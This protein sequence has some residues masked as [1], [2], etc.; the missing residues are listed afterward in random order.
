MRGN[1]HQSVDSF[2]SLCQWL[3][4]AERVRPADHRALSVAGA[5]RG[6]VAPLVSAN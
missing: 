4:V 1:V 2:L 5:E 3:A 6:H